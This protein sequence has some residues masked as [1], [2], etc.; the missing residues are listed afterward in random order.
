T[1]GPRKHLNRKVAPTSWKLDKSIGTY[2]IRPHSGPHKKDLCIPLAY[3]LEKFLEYANNRKEIQIIL[4]S[5]NIKINGKIIEKRKYPV[6]FG[7]VLSIIKTDEHY[8]VFYGVDKNFTFIKIDKEEANFKLAKVTN[9]KVMYENVPYIFTNDGACFKYCDPAININDT[10]KIDLET[11]LVVD[12]VSFKEG[13]VVFVMRGEDTGRVGIIKK[14]QNT[15]VICEDLS[16]KEFET[17]IDSMI[18]IG[19]NEESLLISLPEEKGIRLTALEESN[20]KF[21]EIVEN[22][23][24]V[25]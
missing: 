23:V 18:V 25:N 24:E 6:G 21:G 11:R 3:V 14:I 12:Y 5:K 1:G 19:D 10:V 17:S 16:N 8:R 22:E 2:A 9:K 4:K 20:L 13:D 7:D 15:T